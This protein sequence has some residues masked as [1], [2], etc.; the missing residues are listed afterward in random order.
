MKLPDSILNCIRMLEQAGFAAYVVGGCVRDDCLG[1]IPQDYDMCTSALPEQTEAVF[2]DYRLVLT[3]KKHGTVGVVT[4]DGVVEITTFRTEGEYRDNRHP[5]WVSFVTEVEQDLARR[6]F[7]VNAMAWSPT[8]GYAD[9]FGGRE[10]L[11]N[12]ILRAV[13]DPEKRFREDSL[14]ILRGVRFSVRYQ[15]A[16]EPATEQAMFSQAHLMDNLARERVFEELCKLLPLMQLEDTLRF[17]PVLASVIPEL[18]PMIGFD[19][20]SPHHAYDLYTHVAHVVSAV[21]EELTLRWAALLH[22]IG[23][24]P[25]FTQDETGRGHFYG[26][27]PK[28]A[29]MAEEVLRRLKAPTALRQQVVLLIEKHMLRLE[30]D[31]KILRRRIGQLGWDTVEQ[32]LALQKADM[33]SKGTGKLEEMKIF[34]EISLILEEIRGEDSCLSLKDLAVKGN[35]LM[36]MGYTGKAIGQTLNSLLEQVLDEQLPNEKDA[37]LSWLQTERK[38]NRV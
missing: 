35:D 3:G 12:G 30:P 21:P 15:L 38:E 5:D 2:K 23:K 18:K 19:Q 4:E 31:R 11:K 9:P 28:G 27:A 34:D 20:R 13:G 10:D 36:A 14:R 24:V 1:L 33:G 32:L 29:Q 16:V 7:T 6:D 8:R 26:H 17:A 25:T 37:L 22:D